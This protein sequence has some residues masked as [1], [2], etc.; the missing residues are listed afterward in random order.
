[1]PLK[2]SSSDYKEMVFREWKLRCVAGYDGRKRFDTE[3]FWADETNL[4]MFGAY[5]EERS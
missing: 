2:K 5:D 3:K 4:I 1:M